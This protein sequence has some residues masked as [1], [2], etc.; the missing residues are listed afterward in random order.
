MIDAKKVNELLEAIIDLKYPLSWE[1]LNVAGM[2]KAHLTEDDD[3]TIVIGDSKDNMICCNEY[4][5]CFGKWVISSVDYPQINVLVKI[6]DKYLQD[7]E[8]EEAE[9]D[10][11]ELKSLIDN[12]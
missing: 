1:K 10:F 2:Y 11:N 3:L 4:Q 5:L 9:Q 8:D 12:L 6:A 7:K